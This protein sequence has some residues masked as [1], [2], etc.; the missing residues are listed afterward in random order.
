[1]EIYLTYYGRLTEITGKT[2]EQIEV[3]GVMASDIKKKLG[4]MYPSLQTMQ[5]T[6]AENNALLGENDLFTSKQ[7]DVFPPFSGG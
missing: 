7:L 6:L 2:S 4:S 5:F 1:M 3:E